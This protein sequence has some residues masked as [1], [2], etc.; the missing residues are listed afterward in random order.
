ML[1]LNKYISFDHRLLVIVYFA[2][3]ETAELNR[4][5]IVTKPEPVHV[6]E[7]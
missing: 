3:N 1:E 7:Y 6:S 5:C 2:C 4:L